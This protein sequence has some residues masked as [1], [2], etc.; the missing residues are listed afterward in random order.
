MQIERG[1]IGAVVVREYDGSGAGP[2]CIAIRI[3]AR[4]RSEHHS[5]AIVVWKYERALERAGCQHDLRGAYFPQA[6]HRRMSIGKRRAHGRMFHNCERVVIEVAE[7]SAAAEHGYLRQRAQFSERAPD[8]VER[9]FAVDVR[10]VGQEAAA[11]SLPS[12]AMITRAPARA[13][14]SAAASPAGPPPATS[15]S[16]CAC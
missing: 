7:D 11:N 9:R 8:P 13:A 1:E 12:S 15:T 10:A 3:H 16:Q 4:G 6:L 5:R 2:D 14:A